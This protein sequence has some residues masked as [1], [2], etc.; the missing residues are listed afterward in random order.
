[1]RGAWRRSGAL[2]VGALALSAAGIGARALLDRAR[3]PVTHTVI[4]DASSFRPARLVV[5]AGDRVVWVNEDLIP[6]TATATDGGFDSKAMAAGASWRW[7]VK[8]P[9]ATEYACAFH[10]AMRGRIDAD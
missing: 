2:A 10:P 7:T 9:G 3:P 5:H 8:A 4:I 6:H 1:M